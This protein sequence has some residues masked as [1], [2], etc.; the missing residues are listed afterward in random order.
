VSPLDLTDLVLLGALAGF[1]LVLI[2]MAY[3]LRTARAM[4]AGA[5]AEQ[6]QPS[7]LNEQTGQALR[8]AIE[9]LPHGIAIFDSHDR[10]SFCNTKYEAIFPEGCHHMTPGRS[11]EEILTKIAHQDTFRL[12][13]VTLDRFI[14]QRLARHRNPPDKPFLQP[15]SDGRWI[16]INEARTASYGTLTTWTDVT[17]LKLREQALEILAERGTGERNF[18]EIAAEAIA[19]GLGCRWA[20]VVQRYGTNRARVLAMSDNGAPGALF[21]YDLEGT[22][23]AHLSETTDYCYFPDHI[24]DHFPDDRTLRDMNAVSYIGHVIRDSSGRMTG[25]VFALDERPMGSQ[26]WRRDLIELIARWVDLALEEQQA[27]TTARERTQRLN[28]IIEVG[29]DWIWETGPDL[30]FSY[31]SDRLSDVLGIDAAQLL[32][33]TREE[34]LGGNA[35]DPSWRDH[36]ADLRARKPFRNLE[37]TLQVAD[38]T[39]RHLRINGKPTFDEKGTFLGY[40]GTGTDL[41]AEVAAREESMRNLQFLEAVFENLPEG[42][43]LADADL[44]IVA[45]NRRFLEMLDF[46]PDKFKPGDPFEKFIRYNAERG[47]YGPGDVDEQ[48]RERVALAKRF[49][50]HHFER[51]R[52]GDG[53]LEIRGNPIPRGGF[54]TTYTD[55]TGR[56]HAEETVQQKTAFVELSK[57]VAAAANEATSISQAMA[58]SIKEICRHTAWSI[59][60]VFLSDR[61]ESGRLRSSH[62]WH[63]EQPE[64]HGKLRAFTAAYPFAADTWDAGQNLESG[65]YLCILNLAQEASSPRAHLAR[66]L[67]LEAMFGF[68]IV[69]GSEVCGMLEF[70]SESAGEP[71]PA[72]LEVMTHVGTQLGRVVERASA[73]HSLLAAKEAAEYANR[74]KSEFLATMSHELRTPL[75]AIIGFSELMGREIY[76]PLGHSNYL[77]Y[78]DDIRGSGLHLLKIINDI[79]DV[80]KAEAGHIELSEVHLNLTD[81]VNGAVRLMRP[82][83]QDKPI[84]LMVELPAAP[85]YLL[86]DELRFRQVLLNLLSNAIKFTDTGNIVIRA[87][88]V[89]ELG[90]E[91]QIIDTGIG[92]SEADVERIFEPFAQAD[93]TLSRAHEGTGLGLP[94]SRKLIELHGGTLTLDSTLGKGSVATIRIPHRR[95]VAASDVA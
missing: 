6:P 86:A 9:N 60:H 47:E 84:E 30:R 59:G 36:L 88:A 37:Y 75:N 20:G 40:R 61:G 93:S 57:Q 28:D 71:S 24:T 54:V 35:D 49:Q 17:Q 31:F 87:Q 85:I 22:P 38:G 23:C 32:G 62:I 69:I 78:V 72:T 18:L 46:P 4:A 53:V 55:I 26:S 39:L 65:D 13:D 66:D 8:D 43:S 15:L 70:F 52:A 16:Q 51:P 12:E 42:I 89:P 7:T 45:F 94:L 2:V 10:L 3:K 21:E 82:R 83:M 1:G 27:K 73:Q 41:T 56:K 76:G 19:V 92:V 80:S 95:L 29:A 74:S 25:H 81:A 48:V 91:V 63:M 34:I 14:S 58:I 79:L 68:P 44:N 67:G 33:R 11:F 5:L 90:L 64:A 77:E 50:P